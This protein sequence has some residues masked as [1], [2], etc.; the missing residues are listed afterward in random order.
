MLSTVAPRSIIDIRD[1]VTAL[2]GRGLGSLDVRTASPF[3][4]VLLAR[5]YSIAPA[6]QGS[7]VTEL[8][9]EEEALVAGQS[10]VIIASHRPQAVRVN[11]GV[12]SLSAG[13]TMTATVRNAAGDILK[14]TPLTYAPDFFNQTSAQELLGIALNGDES[15]VFTIDSGSAIIYATWTDNVTQD[16]AM[17]YAVVQ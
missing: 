4:S 11:I 13:A 8:V 7:F 9:P 6:G 3:R 1:V 10:G 16:P 12:R 5:V 2:R 17:Q 15:I 14:V